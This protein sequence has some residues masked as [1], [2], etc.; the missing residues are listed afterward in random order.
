[1]SNIHITIGSKS[2]ILKLPTWKEL[3]DFVPMDIF[4]TMSPFVIKT[5]A[6]SH[7]LRKYKATPA[8]VAQVS[9]VIDFDMS[10]LSDFDMSNDHTLKLNGIDYHLCRQHM[11]NS[12]MR[13]FII[14]DDF[15]SKY[16]EAINHQ[17]PAEDHLY[18]LMG[19]ICRPV[20]A[21]GNYGDRRVSLKNIHHAMTI[22]ATFKR[23]ARS[24]ANKNSIKATAMICL[25]TALATKNFISKTYM[26]HLSGGENTGSRA[27]DFGWHT[28]VM[29]IAENGAFGKIEDVY[30]TNLHDIMV[31][32]VKKALDHDAQVK[33]SIKPT[34]QT[35]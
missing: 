31:F 28:I 4:L 6:A 29:D 18:H 21:K 10:D 34:T 30:N 1:M 3:R 32:C 8:Q 5:W 22:G 25:Y 19:A 15:L 23:H 35:H 17:K 13:E 12:T 16:V 9:Q 7:L 20:S 14:A 24:V 33:N 26:P 2:E 27:I 11:E